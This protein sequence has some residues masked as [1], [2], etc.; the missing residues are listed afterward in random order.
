MKVFEHFLFIVNHKV[1]LLCQVSAASPALQSL[2]QHLAHL[3][4][5]LPWTVAAR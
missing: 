1:I 4:R 5:Q 3:E 2:I